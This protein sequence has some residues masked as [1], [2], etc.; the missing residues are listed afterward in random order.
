MSKNFTTVEEI[1]YDKEIHYDGE[2]SLL[3][4]KL[5]M[6]KKF[7]LYCIE[8]ISLVLKKFYLC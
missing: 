3:L 8:E 5:H 7:Y 6:L 1:H 4:M 2:I